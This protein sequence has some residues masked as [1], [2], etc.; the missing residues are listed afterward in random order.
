[1]YD[2]EGRCLEQPGEPAGSQFHQRIRQTAYPCT[3]LGG[4]IFA[5]LGPG[6]PPLL[7]QYEF[8]LAPDERRVMKWNS[9][10]FQL[11]DSA[12]GRGED[13]GA[14][15]LLPYWLGRYHKFLTCN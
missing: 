6:T 15:F 9:N 8:L 2:T 1:M 11:D 3:E 5:Y 4:I 7:P 13:D 12:D 10:P 14:C